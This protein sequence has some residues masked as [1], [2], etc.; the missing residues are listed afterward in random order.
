MVQ[1]ADIVR[2]DSTRTQLLVR[3]SNPGILMGDVCSQ[4]TAWQINL[5][6]RFTWQVPCASVDGGYDLD[7]DGQQVIV[8]TGACQDRSEWRVWVVDAVARRIAAEYS[9]AGGP[10]IRADGNWD[11]GYKVVGAVEIPHAEERRQA[12]IVVAIA[13]FDLEPRGVIAIDPFA[14]EELW[15]YLVGPKPIAS[16]VCIADLNGDGI[17]QIAFVGSA[18]NNMKGREYNG[19]SDDH[20]RLFVLAA[21][22][23]L[24]WTEA[25]FAG[26]GGADLQIADLNE[27]GK[28]ELVTVENQRGEGSSRLVVWSAE[29]EEL[30]AVERSAAMTSLVLMPSKEDRAASIFVGDTSGALSRWELTE[31]QLELRSEY[32]GTSPVHVQTVLDLAP[33]PGQEIVATDASGGIHVFDAELRLLASHEPTGWAWSARAVRPFI[34]ASG[35]TAMLVL[36]NVNQPG[37]FLDL[38]ASPGSSRLIW[39]L[40]LGLLPLAVVGVRHWK[41]QD[42]Q[43]TESVRDLRLQLLGKLEL[44]NHGAIGVLSYLRRLVWLLSNIQ[45]G[46]GKPDK[47]RSRL[48]DLSNEYRKECLPGLRRIIELAQLAE[49]DSLVLIRAKR[50][51]QAV[52]DCLRVLGTNGPLDAE[53]G[54]TVSSCRKAAYELELSLQEVRNEVHASFSSD[55]WLCWEFVLER[56]RPRIDEQG[57]DVSLTNDG[58]GE[59]AICRI[60]REELVFILDNLLDNALKAMNGM[61]HKNLAIKLSPKQRLWQCLISDTGCGIFPDDWDRAL[62]TPFSSRSGGGLGLPKTREILRKY[63][64]HLEIVDSKPGEGTVFSLGLPYGKPSAV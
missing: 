46:K 19:T 39:F 12:L 54:E 49:T 36:G 64:G 35:Q 56:W 8:L 27:D 34:A 15:R 50:A 48:I 37:L 53:L 60:D 38:V 45:A 5:P 61:D 13:G 9:L 44:S 62:N 41:R 47:L 23:R 29:G 33:E 40:S 3:A 31:R 58:P 57:V 43:S 22:G 4:Q 24:N 42:M 10:D 20:C 30:A 25:L 28:I 17:Q 51:Q 32:R 1:G 55:L 6:P 52:E 7:R 11:G 59:P 21:D 2:I 14:G 18:V 16:T 63:G 26:S